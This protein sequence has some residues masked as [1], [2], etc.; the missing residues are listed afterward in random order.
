MTSSRADCSQSVRYYP[1]TRAE[2]GFFPKICSAFDGIIRYCFSTSF[3]QKTEALTSLST[4]N[5]STV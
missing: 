3:S 2:V 4:G 5:S 1:R